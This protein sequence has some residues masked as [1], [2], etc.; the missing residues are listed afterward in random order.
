MNKVTVT[1]V[2]KSGN[3]PYFLIQWGRRGKGYPLPGE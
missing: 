2:I 3:D 1:R